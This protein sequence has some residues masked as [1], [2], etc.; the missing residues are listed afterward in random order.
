MDE[1]DNT[2]TYRFWNH[3]FSTADLTKILHKHGFDDISFFND[4]LSSGAGYK[5]T[6]LTFC[7]SFNMK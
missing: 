3:F 7:K 6:D 1:L 5:S 4:V 2:E